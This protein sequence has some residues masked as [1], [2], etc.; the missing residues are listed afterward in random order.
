MET[1]A[2]DVAGAGVT[3]TLMSAD[4]QRW[5]A[6]DAGGRHRCWTCRAGSTDNRHTAGE[7]SLAYTPI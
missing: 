5:A 2:R 4:I 3:A 1:V 7:H 6:G